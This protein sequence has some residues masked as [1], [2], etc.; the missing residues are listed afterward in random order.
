VKKYLLESE[1]MSSALSSSG[2]SSTSSSTAILVE[3]NETHAIWNVKGVTFLTPRHFVVERA[4]GV[5]AYGVVCSAIDTRDNARV[6]IKKI[7]HA[8]D[9]ARDCKRTLREIKLL[10]H[11]AQHE[12]ICQ[13]RELLTPRSLAEFDDLYLV[14]LRCDSDLHQIIRSPQPL[15]D[16]HVQYFV[17]QTLCGLKFIHS[18]NVLHRDIKPSNLLINADA[19]LKICD[20]GMARADNLALIA[21]HFLAANDAGYTEY[22]VTRWYR[23]PEVILNWSHYSKPIDVWSTGCVFAELFLRRPL[24]EGQNHIDQVSRTFSIMGTPSPDALERLS[25]DEARQFVRSLGFLPKV[26]LANVI[27]GASPLALDLLE[28]MLVIDPLHRI[29]VDEALEHPYLAQFHDPAAETTCPALFDFT[30]ET[31]Q[32]SREDY[33]LEVFRELVQFH[34]EA[35]QLLPPGTVL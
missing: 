29:G 25:S 17:H 34:P 31:R 32:L 10:R 16:D 24:F 6:A 2:S 11:L 1:A 13:V 27:P 7:S 19:G 8:F 3:E 28:R 20:F 15:S 21:P 33:Q 26:P 14:T 30:F 35:L 9:D 22:V 4:L 12:N 18:A 5:G 23:A